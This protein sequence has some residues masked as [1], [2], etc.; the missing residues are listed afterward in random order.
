[1]VAAKSCMLPRL[2]SSCRDCLW[3]LAWVHAP[4]GRRNMVQAGRG[5]A[6]KRLDRMEKGPPEAVFLADGHGDTPVRCFQ[7]G[8]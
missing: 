1:M 7:D 8:L 3:L 5:M 2:R 6:K 4:T